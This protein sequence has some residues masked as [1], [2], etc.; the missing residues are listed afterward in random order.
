V[1]G[2]ELRAE[3]TL[4]HLDRQPLGDI[5]GT[6]VTL[7]TG[8]TGADFVYHHR[9]DDQEYILDTREIKKN[10]KVFQSAM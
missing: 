4:S 8:N 10:S 9:H 1:K 2:H 5:A 6:M 3:F 7:I